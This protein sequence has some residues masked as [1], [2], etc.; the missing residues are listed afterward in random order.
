MAQENVA[1]QNNERTW[2]TPTY[3]YENL[4]PV[5][6]STVR[7]PEHVCTPGRAETSNTV[8]FETK[9]KFREINF[10]LISHQQF[11]R[12]ASPPNKDNN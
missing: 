7:S 5:V 3:V 12:S 4:V 10:D 9:G 6:C 2:R 11:E 1:V 8:Q